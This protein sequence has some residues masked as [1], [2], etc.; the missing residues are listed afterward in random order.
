MVPKWKE[1]RILGN[2]S[3][4]AHYIGEAY[5]LRAYVYF[6]KLQALGDFPIIRNVMS[7]KD[8]NIL[9]E[10]SKRSPR[11]EVARFIL[12]D[13]DSAITLLNQSSP[14]GKKQRISK[15]VAQLFKS[16]VALY[17]GT[18]LK[19]FSGTAF[20][21]KGPNWPGAAKSYNSNYAFPTG[22]ITGEID[23]FLTQAMESASAVADNIQLENN[24]GI[25]ESANNENPYF[26]MFGAV[27]MSG[28]GEV[29]LWR[30]YNQS[31]VTHNVPV[32]AQAGNYAVGLTRG[33][34][35]SFLMS[36]G[37]PIYAAGSGY[38]GDD[39]IADVRK[40][41]DGRLQ[42]FLKEPGQ[43]NVL[44]NIG[45]GSH[46]TQTDPIPTVYDTDWGRRYTTR[47]GKEFHTMVFRLTMVRDLRVALP[48]EP[49]RPTSIIW[50]LVMKRIKI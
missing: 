14:D 34:V 18:W 42:L 46:A 5:F 7:D 9:V 38:A 25:I 37:L 39:Y 12:S 2:S 4:I 20:V 22:S 32:Y 44:V 48:S 8:K 30:Q 45:Q 16:R 36:N 43:K 3:N 28:Y 27:D 40:N 50:R 6:G 1:N 33:L 17:E 41:R 21:P 49:P 24:T 19:Y 10:A 26:S 15:N 35:E 23:Y 31:L 29:L 47:F 13:L 11:N